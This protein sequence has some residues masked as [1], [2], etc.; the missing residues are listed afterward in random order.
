MDG[1]VNYAFASQ[2][3]VLCRPTTIYLFGIFPA[4]ENNAEEKCTSCECIYICIYIYIYIYINIYVRQNRSM[5]SR[6]LHRLHR[7]NFFPPP[8]HRGLPGSLALHSMRVR[9]T[10]PSEAFVVFTSLFH[11]PIRA[12]SLCSFKHMHPLLRN[13]VEDVQG[14]PSWAWLAHGYGQGNR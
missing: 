10:R 11:I 1:Y 5:H 2:I 9:S 7:S 14:V 8:K 3:I 4:A 12:A 13:L 6:A